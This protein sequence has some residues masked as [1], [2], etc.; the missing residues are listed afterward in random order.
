MMAFL[1]ASLKSA[2][3]VEEP[4]RDLTS[5]ES[6]MDASIS[7]TR[8]MLLGA[9]LLA[10]GT[11]M[12]YSIPGMIAQDAKGSHLVNAFYCSAITLAT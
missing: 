7:T 10:L 3:A 12:F 6:N 11:T 4:H 1:V 2:D 8:V 9:A 5:C